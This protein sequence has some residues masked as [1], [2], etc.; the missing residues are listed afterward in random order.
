MA[1]RFPYAI[2]HSRFNDYVAAPIYAF[3]P[4]R[5]GQIDETY[6]FLKNHGVIAIGT[7]T[8]CMQ[9]VQV[10]EHEQR[11]TQRRVGLD[12]ALQLL[13]ELSAGPKARDF[14]KCH[15]CYGRGTVYVERM[16]ITCPLCG[17]SG[18]RMR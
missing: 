14:S 8:E 1:K 11:T 12:R 2:G 15:R 9:G 18:R 13:E 16:K 7:K 5:P 3:D 17:G 6:P 10:I 4:I